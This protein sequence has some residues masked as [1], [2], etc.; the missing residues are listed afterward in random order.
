MFV[1]DMFVI[2]RFVIDRFVIDRFVID[3]F[4]IDMFSCFQL[5]EVEVNM[6]M[7]VGPQLHDS[8]Y[9]YGIISD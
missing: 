4:V 6:E 3:M 1:I 8:R 2:D 7:M 9:I 5:Q